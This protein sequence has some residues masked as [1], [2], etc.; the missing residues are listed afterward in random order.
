[1]DLSVPGEGALSGLKG[2]KAFKLFVPSI[3][4][5]SNPPKRASY[6]T[7]VFETLLGVPVYAIE[8]TPRPGI[9]PFVHLSL[10]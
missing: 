7:D 4:F 10:V 6:N 9:G 3:S 8:I 1:M 5:S 2:L